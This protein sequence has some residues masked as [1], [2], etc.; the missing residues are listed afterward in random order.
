[1]SDPVSFISR[2]ISIARVLTL[3]VYGT[4]FFVAGMAYE[5][6]TSA[7]MPTILIQT[8]CGNTPTEHA[9]RASET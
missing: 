9:N 7:A 2:Q 1:M 5:H 6:F 4:G 8:G 3:V